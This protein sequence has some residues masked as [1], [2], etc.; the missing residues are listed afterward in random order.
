L[1]DALKLPASETCIPDP[2]T[3][4]QPVIIIDEDFPPIQKE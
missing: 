3:K 2:P 4:L 1:F